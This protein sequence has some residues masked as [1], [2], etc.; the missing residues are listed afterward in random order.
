LI[1]GLATTWGAF[2]THA[3]FYLF[4]DAWR[5]PGW[6]TGMIAATF[7][8]FF[9]LDHNREIISNNLRKIIGI[10]ILIESVVMVV[11]TLITV[12]FR[13]TSIHSALS[14][15]IVAA[16]LNYLHWKK[17]SN[18]TSKF[19]LM[20]ILVFCLSGVVFSLRI[21]P[22]PWFNHV[23]LTHVFLAVAVFLFYNA[24]KRLG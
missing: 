17:N 15:L 8:V 19:I 20:G 24:G 21:S 11:L 6:I 7:F 13:W 3:F 12:N 18:E 16:P 4:N 9:N 14:L 5:M 10:G 23:D 2:V 22:H 1:L